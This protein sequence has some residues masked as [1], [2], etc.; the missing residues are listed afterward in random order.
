MVMKGKKNIF[1]VEDALFLR[2]LL[3]QI[4]TEQGIPVVGVASSAYSALSQIKAL[5]PDLV[6]LDLVLPGQNGL[7]LLKSLQETHPE[8]KIIVCSSLPYKVTKLKEGEKSVVGYVRKPFD[9]DE[10]LSVV[11]PLEHKE[12]RAV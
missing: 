10:L 4:F 11:S 6:L 1:I 8:I 9:V 7:S 5:K 12:P 2:D 3:C